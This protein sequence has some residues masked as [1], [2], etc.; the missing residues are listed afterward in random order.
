MGASIYI[1]DAED[2]QNPGQLATWMAKHSITVSHLTPGI[3]L[4][5]WMTFFDGN[6]YIKYMR[7]SLE[8]VCEMSRFFFS[9]MNQ[10]LTA[11][12]NALM[13]SLRLV[14]LVGDILT[15]RDVLRLQV[16][17]AVSVL[18]NCILYMD[19]YALSGVYI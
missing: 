3:V 10:L 6:L 11:N 8:L 17:G 13:P 14:F 4:E 19:G 1:P 18:V 15:K 7:I 12:A 5:I 16:Q 9:A 2:I